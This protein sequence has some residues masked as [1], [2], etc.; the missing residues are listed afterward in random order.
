MPRSS[1]GSWSATPTSPAP[2]PR[3]P[4]RRRSRR[5]AS[6][7]TG[8]SWRT[9]SRGGPERPPLAMSEET[10]DQHGAYPRLGD[11]QL[12]ALRTAGEELSTRE[13]DVLFEEGQA[14]YDFFVMLDGKAAMLD[15]GEG[16]ERV[17]AVH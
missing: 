8:R 15:S 6:A 5:S 16:G 11:D 12:D 14:P 2:T 17:I 4:C 1:S 9:P 7:S 13:G 10:P 3:G